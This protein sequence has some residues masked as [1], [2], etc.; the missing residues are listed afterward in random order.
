MSPI[1]FRKQKSTYRNYKAQNLAERSPRY[2][3]ASGIA[4]C[5]CAWHGFFVPNS[6]IDFQVGEQGLPGALDIYDINCQH[7]KHFWDRIK[8]WP[9]QLG[10]PDNINQETL[11][12]VVGSFHLSAHVPECFS[13]FRSQRREIYD[14][15][16]RDSN[17]KKMVNATSDSPF[18]G[19]LSP[20]TYH[21]IRG[22]RAP[23]E[24]GF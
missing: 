15:F 8:K 7:C 10:L 17:W 2:L 22:L 13:E 12:F 5:A 19:A 24:H 20:L 16:M 14:D 23:W 3:K 6:V 21:Q 18:W 1:S 9:E 4:A 11:I